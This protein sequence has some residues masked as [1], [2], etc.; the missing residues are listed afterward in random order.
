M[1]NR[2]LYFAYGSNLDPAGM[3][4][5]CPEAE[6]VGR[7]VLVDWRLAFRGVADV[8]P[9]KGQLVHGLVWSCTDECVA[10]LDRYEGVAGGFYRKELLPVVRET[11][12]VVEALVYVMC[13][14]ERDHEAQPSEGYLDTIVRGYHAFGLPFKRLR[15]AVERTHSNAR[16]ARYVPDGPKRLRP[17]VKLAKPRQP[18]RR[19]PTPAPTPLNLADLTDDDLLAN[20][21]SPASIAD[22]RLDPDG[23]V[24]GV[25]VA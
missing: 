12:E 19:E 25:R 15:A 14:D 18:V 17:V 5:R 20:G 7:A 1:T 16:R 2:T 21:W 6:V 23:L 24:W 10:S 3:A 8:E 13:P 4:H 11:G 22:A 9:A